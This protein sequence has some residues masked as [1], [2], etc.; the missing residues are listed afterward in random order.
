MIAISEHSVGE[1][2]LLF[3]ITTS[4]KDVSFNVKR[5]KGEVYLI[6]SP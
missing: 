5:G 6:G 2:E 1:K 4:A 3:K